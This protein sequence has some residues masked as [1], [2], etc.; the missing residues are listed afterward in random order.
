M[1]MG[2]V[3]LGALGFTVHGGDAVDV[4]LRRRQYGIVPQDN[5]VDEALQIAVL[6][7]V[8]SAVRHSIDAWRSRTGF[9][10]GKV[11]NSPLARSAGLVVPCLTS[12]SGR[13]AGS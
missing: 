5:A 13:R 10:L 2:P 9:C 11:G 6:L 3:E 8:G 7:V 12:N 4:G 1:D